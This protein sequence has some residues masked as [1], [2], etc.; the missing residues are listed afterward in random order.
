MAKHWDYLIGSVF[1]S[2]FKRFWIIFWTVGP[3]LKLYSS[4]FLV[5]KSLSWS[6]P[7]RHWD[8]GSEEE[9]PSMARTYP[10]LTASLP[11]P[12]DKGKGQK[13]A[14]VWERLAFPW[15]LE[16]K[17]IDSAFDATLTGSSFAYPSWRC[18]VGWYQ[19]SGEIVIIMAH[20]AK[21]V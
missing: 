8:M 20:I 3:I 2:I 1:A 21:F 13:G 18:L 14:S 15:Y 19:N 11:R 12:E 16:P 10:P 9:H 4:P 5:P 6:S 17:R 7:L